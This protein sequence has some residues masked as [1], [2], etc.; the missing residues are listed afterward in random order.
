MRSSRCSN[1]SAGTSSATGGSTR[2][3]NC[4]APMPCCWTSPPARSWRSRANVCRLATGGAGTRPLR[5][6]RLQGRLGARR[7]DPWSAPDCARTA[8]VH[9]GGTL[10]EITAA[11]QA[12][13]DGVHPERPFVLVAQPAL[14]DAHRA[15]AGVHTAWAC[16]HVPNGSTF[17]M[18]HRIEA[19]LE[20]FAPGFR[21]RISHRHV[22]LTPAMAA[23]DANYVGGDIAG[24]AGDL[25]Q[26]V[27]RP[28]F[29][30]HPWRTPVDGLWMCSSSTP[31]GA[32][33]ARDVRLPGRAR[34]AASVTAG[35]RG[36]RVGRHHRRCG[37][38]TLS[39]TFDLD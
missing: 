35:R 16:C 29:G 22:M 20:R 32:G 36:C 31:P 39:P 24:G 38:S 34:R 26:F 6:G 3:T 5:P 23:H 14:F 12:V 1:R 28:T 19:Q 17:D 11:E 10:A 27:A 30:L 37:V 9:V 21:D 13:Q 4:R 2:S 15:P 7:P 8:T 18:S 25:R 33:R